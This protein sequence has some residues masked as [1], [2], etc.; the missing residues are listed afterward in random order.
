MFAKEV[1]VTLNH[2]IHSAVTSAYKFTEID[3]SLITYNYRPMSFRNERYYSHTLIRTSE[4]GMSYRK[5]NIQAV[6]IISCSVAY[7]VFYYHDIVRGTTV[8][9]FIIAISISLLSAFQ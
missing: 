3:M 2:T 6:C 4:C 5:K 8:V 7:I 1:P 9:C